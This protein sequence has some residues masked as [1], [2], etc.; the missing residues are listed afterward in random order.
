MTGN[1]IRPAR[2]L[3]TLLAAIFLTVTAA[4]P[5][6]ASPS[7]P[8]QPPGLLTLDIGTKLSFVPE[9]LTLSGDAVFVGG[10]T[11]A[12]GH[13][14]RL[15]PVD[16]SVVAEMP[17][18]L[19]IQNLLPSNDGRFLYVLG[20]ADQTTEL[21]VF[22]AK[23]HQISRLPIGTLLTSPTLS[24]VAEGNIAVSGLL[25]DLAQGFSRIVDLQN[26]D[27]PVLVETPSSPLAS[28]WV[29]NG[30]FFEPKRLAFLNIA[31]RAAL[32]AV[33]ADSG[34]SVS[35]ISGPLRKGAG[36]EPFAVHASM[37]GQPCSAGDAPTFLISDATRDRLLLAEYAPQFSTLNILSEVEP[38]FGIR[39]ANPAMQRQPGTDALRSSGIL[40]SSCALSVVWLGNRNGTDVIQYAVNAAV[41]SLE[42]IGTLTLPARPIDLAV[43]PDGSFAIALLPH[44]NSILRYGQAASGDAGSVIGNMQVRELQR[45]LTEQGFPVGTIDG[46]IG[47]QTER[48]LLLFQM[49]NGVAVNPVQDI[50]AAL[51]TLKKFGG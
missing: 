11:R 17:L 30:W 1:D 19:Q 48:A 46:I 43:S 27:V 14:A 20:Q 35:D 15:D 42:K 12:G 32:L 10:Y 23:L 21:L 16:L 22:D 29:V 31:D 5:G 51:Q 36:V 38:G 37:P 40:A 2:P 25:S 4:L 44:G 6:A 3:S 47:A 33:D 50:D 7:V 9:H 41:R 18:K 26:P 34:R 8:F 24:P 39:A 13:L 49:V 28:R 45:L